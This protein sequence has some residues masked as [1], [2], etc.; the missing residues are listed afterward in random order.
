MQI[1]FRDD[2]VFVEQLELRHDLTDDKNIEMVW[3]FLEQLKE[4]L[5]FLLICGQ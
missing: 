2:L 4:K 1:K 3:F 5:F